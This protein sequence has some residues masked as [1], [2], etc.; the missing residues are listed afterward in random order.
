MK[1]LLAALLLL[2]SQAPGFCHANLDLG[3]PA[4]GTP[5]DPY[6]SPVKQVL[7]HLGNQDPSIDQVRHLMHEGRE[8]RYSFT[9]PYV[10]ATPEETAASR[11]GDCKAKALWLADQLNDNNVRFVIGKARSS[12]HMSHAWLMWQHQNRW[13]I[14]DCTNN[15]DPIPADHVASWEYIPYYSFAKTGEYRHRATE[16]MMASTSVVSTQG[17]IAANR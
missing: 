12:S 8:F 3:L 17:A 1:L 14:L 13:Y 10:A 4:S 9:S 16:I 2:A 15:W 6:M 7:T 11:S 5:Y